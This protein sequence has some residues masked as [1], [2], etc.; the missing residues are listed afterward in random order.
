MKDPKETSIQ[1]EAV[2]KPVEET[3]VTKVFVPEAQEE[4]KSNLGSILFLIFAIFVMAGM[5]VWYY[6][7][8]RPEVQEMADD[9]Q[10]SEVV[11]ADIEDVST[12]KLFGASD[13]FFQEEEY[14][15][16]M[17]SLKEEKLVDIECTPRYVIYE[18]EEGSYEFAVGS[19][20]T[21]T[22]PENATVLSYVEKQDDKPYMITLCE[23]VGEK[24]LVL[25][26]TGG[27]GGGAGNK[28]YVAYLDSNLAEMNP[29]EVPM[30]GVAYMNCYQP[31]AFTN[32]NE[33]YYACGGGD[34]G[35]GRS[36]IYKFSLA[37]NAYEELYRCDS[38]ISNYPQV[39]CGAPN[40]NV[41]KATIEEK[42]GVL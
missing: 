28:A 38:N 6:Y 35:S 11:D 8:S 3:P 30:D 41:Y 1:P 9:Y 36:S 26:E 20:H 4:K 32:D 19:Q 23:T 13:L 39:S 25:R 18:S 14:P 34:G 16:F 42:Q 22:E 40:T 29:I 7:D 37:T 21:L 2:V 31:L 27:S 5:L 10:I 24:P 33:L 17:H 15:A 12:K